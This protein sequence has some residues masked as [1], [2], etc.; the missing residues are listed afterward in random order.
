M[1]N[2]REFVSTPLDFLHGCYLRRVARLVLAL[3][4]WYFIII[5]SWRVISLILRTFLLVGFAWLTLP[6]ELLQSLPLL[7]VS[8]YF[9]ILWDCFGY[10]FRCYLIY[11]IS[12]EVL[13]S[14]LDYLGYRIGPEHLDQRSFY[15]M[16]AEILVGMIT[17]KIPEEVERPA[18]WYHGHV[19]VAFTLNDEVF[20]SHRLHILVDE[21]RYGQ[22]S[23][24]IEVES[25]E[26]EDDPR[27]ENESRLTQEKVFTVLVGYLRGNPLPEGQRAFAN[28][29]DRLYS[30]F[31]EY[32][33][34]RL[35]STHTEQR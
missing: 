33:P 19:D 13:D 8:E 12:A 26:I 2:F 23:I 18:V 3:I 27:N 24:A 17:G 7:K 11:K 5:I 6:R 9:E 15:N 35:E 30:L 25:F 31:R 1:D 10:C 29:W 28:W 14:T 32:D 34:P 22:R 4:C 21:R 16:V 20:V